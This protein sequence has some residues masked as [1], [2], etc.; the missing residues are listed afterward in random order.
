ML[1]CMYVCIYYLNSRSTKT[2]FSHSYASIWT[3]DPCLSN[4]EYFLTPH[5]EPNKKGFAMKAVCHVKKKFNQT[6]G[7]V[8]HKSYL[9]CV[10][11]A[12][13][14]AMEAYMYNNSH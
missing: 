9:S 6:A 11:M 1:L 14:I 12:T 2:R 4:L 5:W 3:H 8:A 13:D 10:V 7:Q